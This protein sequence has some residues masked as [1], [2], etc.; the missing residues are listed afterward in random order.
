MHTFVHF[1]C[2]KTM[3]SLVNASLADQSSTIY[4]HVNHNCFLYNRYTIENV[5]IDS[6]LS[7]VA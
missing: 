4:S 6:A 3:L 2:G 1:L 5:I 7:K